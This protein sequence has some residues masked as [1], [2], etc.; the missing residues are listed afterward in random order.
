MPRNPATAPRHTP[1]RL[2]IRSAPNKAE[3][4]INDPQLMGIGMEALDQHDRIDKSTIAYGQP[5]DPTEHGR[6][7]TQRAIFEQVDGV[8]LTA[9]AKEPTMNQALRAFQ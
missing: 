5:H 9:N 3:Q 1:R 8:T 7:I 6:T 2:N 4:P